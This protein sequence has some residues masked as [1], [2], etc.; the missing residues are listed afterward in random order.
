MP[1]PTREDAGIYIKLLDI[2]QS[3][4]QAEARRWVLGDFKCASYEEL[5]AKH[6]VGSV[7]RTYLTSVMAFFES[8]G[9][10]VSRGLLNEDVFFD[11]PLGFEMLWPMVKHI[12]AD[13]QTGAGDPAAWENVQWLGIRMD[14]W[15]EQSWK[16][17]L[18]A[19]PPDR[20]PE[21]V[22][23]AIRGFQH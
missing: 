1:E 19:I 9:V 2:S 14:S 18:E 22:E 21:K 10:L 6:A 23:P 5:N 16:S 20:P 17:K 15:K 4:A 12:I 11:A 3:G 8:V 7:E 13:W